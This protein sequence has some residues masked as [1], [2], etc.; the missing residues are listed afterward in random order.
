MGFSLE[1][2]VMQI[3]K[4]DKR[5]TNSRKKYNWQIKEESEHLEKRKITRNWEYWKQ[6]PLNKLRWKKK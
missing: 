3:I 5:Q 2:Y 6:T 1:K 4:S